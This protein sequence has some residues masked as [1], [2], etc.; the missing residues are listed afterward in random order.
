M[1]WLQTSFVFNKLEISVKVSTLAGCLALP[2]LFAGRAGDAVVRL[3][4]GV[5]AGTSCDAP[6][7]DVAGLGLGRRHGA[8]PTAHNP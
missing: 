3:Q 1:T 5:A 8:L 6:A 7:P 4:P 2:E